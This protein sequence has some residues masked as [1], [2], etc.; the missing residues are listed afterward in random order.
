MFK[1]ARTEE[2]VID[3]HSNIGEDGSEVRSEERLELRPEGSKEELTTIEAVGE[4][5]HEERVIVPVHVAT[6]TLEVEEELDDS[7]LWSLLIR[8]GYISW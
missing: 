6:A 4:S 7:L 3:P 1:R 5:I 8:A 2:E